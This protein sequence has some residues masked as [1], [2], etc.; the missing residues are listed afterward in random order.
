MGR[1]PRRASYGRARAG[2]AGDA[3]DAMEKEVKIAGRLASYE[4]SRS[5]RSCSNTTSAWSAVN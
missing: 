4:T 5:Y 2:V 1:P 3:D